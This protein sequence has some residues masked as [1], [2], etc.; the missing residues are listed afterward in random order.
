MKVTAYLRVSTDKQAE[1]GYGLEVQRQGIRKWAKA[2]GHQVVSW[3]ADEGISGSNGL[4]TREALGD[5]LHDL[6]TGR[7]AGL[8]VPRL[9]R[10]SRE[11]WLQ[12]YLLREIRA[13][14]AQPFSIMASEQAVID[15]DPDD[16][17]RKLHRVIIGA[18]AEY[19]RE[20]IK[21]RLRSGQRRKAALGGYAGGSPPYGYR[22]EGKEL[23]PVPAEQ[24]TLAR[25]RELRAAGQSIRQI[26]DTL[27]AEG[28]TSKRGGR[29]HVE[30]VRRILARTTR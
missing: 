5:A 30:T 7:A 1:N 4:T 28:Y 29:W 12:E 16:P 23:V 26:A 14:G 2:N 20:L 3:H 18:I 24:R 25:I 21:L 15:D 11:M 22:A 13:H 10:L 9:D 17:G 8:V 27:T 19:E 6:E